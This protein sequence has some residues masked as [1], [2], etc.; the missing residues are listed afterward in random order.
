MSLVALF[1]PSAITNPNYGNDGEDDG[2]FDIDDFLAGLQQEST[3]A[4][5]NPN[6]GGVAGKID[7]ETQD[8]SPIDSSRSTVGSTQGSTNHADVDVSKGVG[9]GDANVFAKGDDDD[10]DKDANDAH[11]ARRLMSPGTSCNIP[12]P[13][14]NA[15]VSELQTGKHDSAQLQQLGP[16]GA[17]PQRSNLKN[18][19]LPGHRHLEAPRDVLRLR[20][21]TTAPVRPA[22]TVS[23]G[24]AAL[25]SNDEGIDNSSDED[26][27]EASDAAPSETRGRPHSRKRVKQVKDAEHNDGES[28]SPCPL[29]VSYQ[30]ITTSPPDGMQ[31]SEEIPISG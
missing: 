7:D 28:P 31:E 24:P 29:N 6:A 12:A 18:G 21:R 23:I 10:N 16:A 14:S 20:S 17:S 30:A 19:P 26:Y 13:E 1:D 22:S 5:V 8:D 4:I 15:S 11:S 25:E 3:S 2:F 27:R 9:D